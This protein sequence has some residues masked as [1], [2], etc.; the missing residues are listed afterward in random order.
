MHNSTCSAHAQYRAAL[1]RISY[2]DARPT[3][4]STC[5]PIHQVPAPTVRAVFSNS[6]STL[7]SATDEESSDISCA[8]KRSHVCAYMFRGVS[9]LA[10]AHSPTCRCTV[11]AIYIYSQSDGRTPGF[12]AKTAAQCILPSREPS[13]T[14][15]R[16]YTFFKNVILM[17]DGPGSWNVLHLDRTA[18]SRT[19]HG[20]TCAQGR[21]HN[22]VVQ[23][24]YQ[25]ANR[26]TAFCRGPS[27][28]RS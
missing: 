11:P 26:A 24:S 1:L 12:S 2:D 16:T 19:L 6:T 8:G 27:G 7:G 14:G 15:N 28:G 23:S 10:S 3:V 20:D 21:E 25:F 13:Q 18:L 9:S 22:I 5:A 17:H 4:H